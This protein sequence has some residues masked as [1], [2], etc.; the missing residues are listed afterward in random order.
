MD[1]HLWADSV[2]R[3]GHGA[4]DCDSD[5]LRVASH[6]LLRRERG[7]A[8]RSP[9]ALPPVA[10]LEERLWRAYGCRI[11]AAGKVRGLQVVVDA[12]NAGEIARAQIATL[13]L[14]LP[15]PAT[16]K[17]SASELAKRLHNGGWLLKDWNPSKHPRTGTAPNP[18]WFALYAGC[19]QQT[20]LK[21]DYASIS[22]KY[23]LMHH[24]G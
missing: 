12:L 22:I 1:E 5:G 24:F 6:D 7:E 23:R 11:S 14:K 15:D 21:M 9:Y 16:A 4:V 10:E 3:L 13:L 17:R 18:G 2:F 8:S 20:L 19:G